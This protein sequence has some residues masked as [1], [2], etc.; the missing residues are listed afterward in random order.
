[1]PSVPRALVD[2]AARCA[3]ENKRIADNAMSFVKGSDDSSVLDR[4]RR[5]IAQQARLKVTD[6]VK[7]YRQEKKKRQEEDPMSEA[8]LA[9]AQLREKVGIDANR[10]RSLDEV[11]EERRILM[12]LGF[13]DEAR[14]MGKVAQDM[15]DKRLNERRTKEEKMLAQRLLMVEHAQKGRRA[16]MGKTLA[17]VNTHTHTHTHIYIYIYIYIYVY[18]YVYIYIC[19]YIYYI[20][21]ICIYYVYMYVYIYTYTYTYIYIYI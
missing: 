4:T 12:R 19:I 7:S 8:G 9:R 13:A 17:E 15:R 18:I 2:P 16:E 3:A 10:Q 5:E 21:Y 14:E 11:V 6:A 20:M 1:V